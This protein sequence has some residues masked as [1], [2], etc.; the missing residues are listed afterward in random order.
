MTISNLT[1]MEESYPNGWKTLLEKEKLLVTSSVFNRLVSQGRLKVSLCGNGLKPLFSLAVFRENP[2]Y[3]YS[4]CVVIIVIVVFMQKLWHFVISLLLLKIFTWNL[5]YV[6][7][8]QRAIHAIKGDNSRC[9]FFFFLKNYAPFS[10]KTFYPL[11]ST[12]QP[13]VG[14]CMWCSC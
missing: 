3:Y 4:F 8:I 5:E 1:K 11:S 9:S 12:P 2:R 6:F 10:T 13:S 7:T 14:T